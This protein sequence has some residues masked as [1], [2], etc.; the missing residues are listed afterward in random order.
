MSPQPTSASG[1]PKF[2]QFGS[3]AP[4]A[5]PLW[6]SRNVSPHYTTSHRKLRAAVRKYYDEEI[7]PYAFEWESA[8]KVPDEVRE[9]A[10]CVQKMGHN[11][12]NRC[13]KD[14]PNWAT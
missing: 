5:E 9:A 1:Q 12:E 6:Y 10:F 3:T 11:R 13:L 7:I 4:Y 14:M 8:G 2:E